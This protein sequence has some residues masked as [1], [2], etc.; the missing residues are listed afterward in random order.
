MQYVHVKCSSIILSSC[1]STFYYKQALYT[2]KPS[3]RV[4]L[5]EATVNII[6]VRLQYAI[7]II[8]NE[9]NNNIIINLRTDNV[10]YYPSSPKKKFL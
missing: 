6:V 3:S 9:V 5:H 7:I 4:E 10:L 8:N 2:C 1:K